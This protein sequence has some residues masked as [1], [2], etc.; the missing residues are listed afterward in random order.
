MTEKSKEVAVKEEVDLA[1][2]CEMIGEPVSEEDLIK[3]LEVVQDNPDIGKL[4]MVIPD[5]NKAKE[6]VEYFQATYMELKAGSRWSPERLQIIRKMNP[7]EPK[8]LLGLFRKGE[9]AEPAEEMTLLP[10]ANYATKIYWPPYGSNTGEKKF[11]L[12][13]T[14]DCIRGIYKKDADTDPV[15]RECNGCVF[16]QRGFNGEGEYDPNMNARPLCTDMQNFVC[17]TPDFNKLYEIQLQKFDLDSR[18]NTGQRF[19]TFSKMYRNAKL[20][21]MEAMPDVSVYHF[22]PAYL[23]S[24]LKISG[25]PV[26]NK[27][28][29][30]VSAVVLADQTKDMLTKLD[31]LYALIFRV[32]AIKYISHQLD[33]FQSRIKVVDYKEVVDAEAKTTE[34]PDDHKKKD[35]GGVEDEE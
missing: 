6:I 26:E 28:G 7:K 4:L 32:W 5:K 10:I 12:C 11:S 19:R 33:N 14:V 35:F 25:S 31:A 27:N 24:W 2:I 16:N 30:I 23:S 15:I 34:V 22:D 8:F 13:S 17:V 18:F 3:G 1:K 21:T 20:E 9:D 29:D